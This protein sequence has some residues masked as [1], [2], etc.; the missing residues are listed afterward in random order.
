[1]SRRSLDIDAGQPKFATTIIPGFGGGG[2][3]GCF[4]ASSSSSADSSSSAGSS[5]SASESSSS[6]SSSSESSSSSSSSS[7]VYP[8]KRRVFPPPLPIPLRRPFLLWP[9]RS[10]RI[11]YLLTAVLSPPPRLFCLGRLLPAIWTI[12]SLPTMEQSPPLPPLPP[13]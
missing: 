11:L 12:T 9:F 7:S 10:A 8:P 6:V 13:T 5:S 4:S 3:G 2:T 1:M